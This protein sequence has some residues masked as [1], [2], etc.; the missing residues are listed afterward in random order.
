MTST[1][2]RLRRLQSIRPQRSRPELTYEPVDDDGEPLRQAAPPQGRLEAL[3]PGAEATVEAG[4]CY[5]VTTT[6]PLN[7]SRGHAA[8]GEVMDLPPA[9]LAPFHPDFALESRLDFRRAAFVDTE[10]TGLGAGAGVYAFMV[11]VGTF[12]GDNADL[13]PDRF[14]VRQFFMRHP[15][16]E[17]ALLDV[18][19]NLMA[20]RELAVTFNGRAFDLPLLRARYRQTGR[21]LAAG[22][23]PVALFEEGSPHLDLLLPA[24]RLWRRRLQSCR[25]LNLEQH[26][27]GLQ[28]SEDD[29]P[30]SLIPQ[31]Y[32]DFVRSGQAG[33]MRRVFYHNREDIVSMVALARHLVQAYQEP[34]SAPDLTTEEWLALGIS[35]EQ[36]DEPQR[37]ED[38]YRHT[39]GAVGRNETRAE[40]YAQLGALLK[41]QERWS[42]ACNVWQEW[43][44]TVPGVDPAPFVEL[45]KYCEWQ[46][47]D[48]EQAEMWTGWAL[49]NL[50]TAPAHQRLPGQV[51]ELEHRLTRIRR[52]RG[53][54]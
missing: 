44:T 31:L 47:G 52:K 28:R 12:E 48:L 6:Y 20:D 7:T 18:V 9:V 10:T 21:F 29:V 39:I 25:L 4:A 2:D 42:E 40:A 22:P 17:A 46:A 27:L 51:A 16:E 34:A 13:P 53:T 15:G 14:V 3:V 43:L 36:R 8:L 30:G 50:R 11:G 1:L 32:V 24:R 26:I 49:H 33:E 19:A 38:A 5:V 54:K 37:A 41:R 23:Q 35:F 45:A